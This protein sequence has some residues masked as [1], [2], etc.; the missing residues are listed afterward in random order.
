MSR[1]FRRVALACIGGVAGVL[2]FSVSA[3]PRIR[4]FS[5]SV[6]RRSVC[7]PGDR[8]RPSWLWLESSQAMA[9]SPALPAATRTRMRRPE[10]AQRSSACSCGCCIALPPHV[11]R[12]LTSCS[13]AIGWNGPHRLDPGEMATICRLRRL[14]SR[15]SPTELTTPLQPR[16]KRRGQPICSVT[17]SSKALIPF[18]AIC[19][20]IQTRKNDDNCVITVIPVAHRIR[21]SW[22]AN[23]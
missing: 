1:R 12:A 23:P 21:A 6:R 8:R 7:S 14:Q 10:V 9:I 11:P 15:R 20:P 18:Q 3:H 22:S 2:A 13:V 4:A 19:T 16:G 17:D 5:L